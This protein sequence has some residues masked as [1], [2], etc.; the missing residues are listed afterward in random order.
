MALRPLEAENAVI[1][2]ILIDARCLRVV[3]ELLRP[4]DFALGTNQD[5]YRAV[6]TLDRNGEKIDPVTIR[7][8]VK[9]AGTE[10][11]TEYMIELM[12]LTPTAGNAEEYAKIT[13]EDSLCRSILAV[14]EGAKTRI[15]AAEDP[16][17]VLSDQIR[18]LE[19]L[20]QE[21]VTKDLLTPEDQM[22]RFYAHRD[23]VDSGKISA[24]VPTGYRDLDNLLGGGMLCSGM[25]ILAARPGMGKTT[26]AINI[27]DRVAKRVGPVLFVSLEMDDEQITAKRISRESGIPGNKLLMGKLDEDEYRRMQKAADIVSTLPLTI[28][29]KPTA[30]IDQIEDMAGKVKDLK[31]I[32]IDYLG[33]I[34]PGSRGQ[35]VSRYEYTT[36]ISGAVKD[37][38]R[39]FKIPVLLL[40]QLNR[41]LE[42]R[43][44][45]TPQLS[46]LRDTGAAEQD[47]D[48]VLFLYRPAYYGDESTRDRFAPE[49]TSLNLAKNRHGSVGECELAFGLAV[50]KVTAVSNDPRVAYRNAIKYGNE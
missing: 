37:L 6:L 23:A 38:A 9:R 14:S 43:S 34:S 11:S 45:H 21:G 27:A 20:R 8:A 33:K 24:Y 46:D 35:K 50:S 19:G 10:V 41:E 1:G 4:E 48:G 30:T 31:L 15:D 40:A 29:A 18:E 3:K 47:A 49:S 17:T 44:D 16:Q 13:R 22:L 42:K 12:N 26:L 28:N 32:V 39:K 36:E 2:S 5:I 25:Y 7:N